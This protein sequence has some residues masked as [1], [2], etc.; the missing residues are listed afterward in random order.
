[1]LTDFI[2]FWLLPALSRM[3]PLWNLSLYMFLSSFYPPAPSFPVYVAFASDV[4]SQFWPN[5][6]DVTGLA[7]G[8]AILVI[9]PDSHCYYMILFWSYYAVSVVD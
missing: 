9:E 3:L 4:Y 2:S 5:L 1:M 6:T 8:G 7:A